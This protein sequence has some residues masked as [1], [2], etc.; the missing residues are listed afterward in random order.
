MN[1]SP[2]TAIALVCTLTPSP[3]PSSSE[4]MATQV[5]E[6]LAAHGVPGESVRIIDQSITPGVE[7]DMGSGDGWPALRDRILASDILL[8]STPIWM[9]HASSLAQVVMERLDAELSFTD[10]AG[11]P[12]LYGK[13]AIVSVVG[14]EDGAHKAT[15]DLFQ[16]L[17]DVG[18][19]IP[20]QGG[21]YWNGEAMQT[22]DYKDLD[23]TPDPVASA[24]S[25]MAANAAH[26]ARA[27]KASNYP[28]S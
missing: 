8:V 3:K 16:A 14:N 18:F 23:S 21:T 2:L 7:T 15:A 22:V 11:R 24:T 9:G 28:A 12:H 27:L 20:A 1:P 13:V 19:T 26:L 5:L 4:L 6:Q 25:A 17:N 10:A